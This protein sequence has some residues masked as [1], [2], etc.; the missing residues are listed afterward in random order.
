VLDPECS[1]EVVGVHHR[2]EHPRRQVVDQPH[3]PGR[4]GDRRIVRMRLDR[5]RRGVT[6]FGDDLERVLA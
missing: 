2:L 6:L 4:G 5:S 1:G 3:G